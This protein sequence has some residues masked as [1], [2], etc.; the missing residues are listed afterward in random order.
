MLEQVLMGLRQNTVTLDEWAYEWNMS[1]I[2]GSTLRPS[3]QKQ[4]AVAAALMN[5]PFA[6]AMG[7]QNLPLA[8]SMLAY[9]LKVND[10]DPE[11]IQQMELAVQQTMQMQQ[12]QIMQM[13]QPP[14]Q[15]ASPLQ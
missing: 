2:P 14:M 9:S 1:I 15:G 8:M 5:Q 13:Q 10:A 6:A 3:V 4:Q 11:I 7:A 12:Q